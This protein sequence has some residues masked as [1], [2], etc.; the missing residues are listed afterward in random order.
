ME[1]PKKDSIY[2]TNLRNITTQLNVQAERILKWKMQSTSELNRQETELNKKSHELT[3]LQQK[4]LSQRFINSLLFRHIADFSI[5]DELMEM[6]EEC[7]DYHSSHLQAHCI[8]LSSILKRCLDEKVQLKTVYDEQ[9]TNAEELVQ[10]FQSLL[11]FQIPELGKLNSMLV[12]ERRD[13]I[14]TY[15]DARIM[16]VNFE[17]R[18][19]SLTAILK[20]EK[21]RAEQLDKQLIMSEK[22]IQQLCKAK[23]A[24]EL[25]LEQAKQRLV[26]LEKSLTEE[27]GILKHELEQTQ[28]LL[29]QERHRV[30]SLKVHGVQ[31]LA[32]LQEVEIQ[33]MLSKLTGLTTEKTALEGKVLE[34]EPL[35]QEFAVLQISLDTSLGQKQEGD[36]QLQEAAVKIEQLQTA[37]ATN[38]KLLEECEQEREAA[39]EQVKRLEA[40]KLELDTKLLEANQLIV[41]LTDDI[42]Q[43]EET[44]QD[45]HLEADL[46]QMRETITQEQDRTALLTTQLQEREHLLEEAQTKSTE[47]QTELA[48]LMEERNI[49][50]F[51]KL[52][53]EARINSLLSENTK[54]SLE[55][56]QARSEAS[57]NLKYTQMLEADLDI[58]EQETAAVFEKYRN[59]CETLSRQ[60]KESCEHY[61]QEIDALKKENTDLEEQLSKNEKHLS[62]TL[63]KLKEQ[64]DKHEQKNKRLLEKITHQEKKLRVKDQE[65]KVHKKT[66]TLSPR[67]DSSRTPPPTQK[68]SFGMPVTP[69]IV[70]AHSTETSRNILKSGMATLTCKRV[71][72]QEESS[73]TDDSSAVD[74]LVMDEVHRR[75]EALKRGEKVNSRPLHVVKSPSKPM[76]RLE[77]STPTTKTE[78]SPVFSKK[79]RFVDGTASR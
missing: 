11:D 62:E 38:E 63:A 28:N 73:D 49:N 46:G 34:L 5:C 74:V 41:Q 60:H 31:Y 37:V 25:E 19:E 57:C 51:K 52:Q 72:L 67:T 79:P 1:S 16:K 36:L 29:I 6:K 17:Q 26:D 13:H 42:K 8:H 27:N 4:Y 78:Q 33:K 55:K 15:I 77:K 9:L 75:M 59:E 44:V 56:N 68:P 47:Q 32:K 14:N 54:L 40:I 69:K 24:N 18:L 23:E 65:M 20:A 39:G 22:T 66:P 58:K 70:S 48:R 3:M 30:E 10:K 7:N 61:Q 43:L 64:A 21:A 2:Q 71:M 76:K 35:R 12:E 45:K 50:F 53:L